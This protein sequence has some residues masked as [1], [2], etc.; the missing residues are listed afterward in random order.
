MD[1]QLRFL[2]ASSLDGADA[3]EPTVGDVLRGKER[4][5]SDLVHTHPQETLRD[6]I[7]ILREYGAPQM[8]VVGAERPSWPARSPVR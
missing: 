4:R 5:P 2:C 6:A 1:E 3:A 7:E 8:P